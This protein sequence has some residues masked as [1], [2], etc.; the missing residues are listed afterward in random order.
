MVTG[1]RQLWWWRRFACDDRGVS[2]VEFALILPIMLLL[3]FGATELGDA[4]AIDR[5]V[6]HVTSTL[7]D[8]V[9]QSK[10][11]TDSDMANIFNIAKSIMT[12]YSDS[13]L[14]MKVTGVW[15]DS[16]KNATVSWG[17]AKNDTAL[18]KGASVTLPSSQVQAS[19]FLVMTEVH[20]PYTPTVGYVMTGSYDLT[21]TFY[22]R[23]RLSDK[24]CQNATSC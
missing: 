20:Y 11:I 1:R 4:L 15:I 23:P 10:S 22:L 14:K 17:Y 6:G 8:L 18:S 9:T 16:S 19:T 13:T 12:P 21:D 7:T 3:F 2:A 24:I 5:K